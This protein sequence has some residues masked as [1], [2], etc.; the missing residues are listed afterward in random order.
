M[1]HPSGVFHFRLLVPAN[2]REALGKRISKVT[3]A[4]ETLIS[5]FV[6]NP[7]GT[8]DWAID[9]GVGQMGSKR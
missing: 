5:S 9:P 2:L 6:L 1:R 3:G 8:P 4:R 7:A